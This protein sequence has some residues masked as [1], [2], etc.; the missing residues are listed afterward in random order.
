MIDTI[1]IFSK[2]SKETYEKIKKK[3]DIKR[4]FSADTGEVYYDIINSHLKGSFDTNISVRP[5]IR[6]EI[7]ISK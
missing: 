4:G 1:K 3:S 6:R 2:I 5:D 7:W